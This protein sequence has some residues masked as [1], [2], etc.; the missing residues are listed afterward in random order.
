[1]KKTL[2][3]LCLTLAALVCLSSLSFLFGCGGN[4]PG[5]E[6]SEPASEAESSEPTPEP[7]K[8]PDEIVGGA[9]QK[10][11]AALT[12]APVEGSPLKDLSFL[13]ELD[14]VLLDVDFEKFVLNGA[15]LDFGKISASWT[16]RE[17]DFLGS[18][19]FPLGDNPIEP[20]LCKVGTAYYLYFNGYPELT[21]TV[22]ESELPD[23]LKSI[24]S[25]SQEETP[26]ASVPDLNA[27]KERVEDLKNLFNNPDGV[28]FGPYEETTANDGSKVYTRTLE[29]D[30][31]RA[32]V[33]KLKSL[34]ADLAG[35]AG[36]T[37][38]PSEDPGQETSASEKGEAVRMTQSWALSG[39]SVSSGSV[40][41]F[42]KDDYKLAEITFDVS[43]A[44]GKTSVSAV[45]RDEGETVLEGTY[46]VGKEGDKRT[47]SGS[48]SMPKN[49]FSAEL[50]LTLEDPT[51]TRVAFSATLK[52]TTENDGLTVSFPINV[53]GSFERKPEEEKAAVATLHVVAKASSYCDIDVT[54]KA[55]FC[56]TDTDIS[57][58]ENA[59]PLRSILDSPT[60]FISKMMAAFPA[61]A[62][63][64]GQQED[65]QFETY[66]SEDQ[67]AGVSFSQ[68]AGGIVSLYAYG[69]YT[70]NGTA[71]VITFGEGE[72]L[73]IPY[74]KPDA[75]HIQ[76]FGMELQ[77]VQGDYFTAFT[78]RYDGQ[79]IWYGDEYLYME[80]YPYLGQVLFSVTLPWDGNR[81][82]LD[83]TYPSGDSFSFPLTW[84]ENGMSC[85]F[86]NGTTL[87][88]VSG[89]TTAL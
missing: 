83:F 24:A 10:L 51:E 53:D 84:S 75:D 42:G 16:Q 37:A 26:D 41:V 88:R 74:V 28:S 44:D 49:G 65:L 11:R 36:E 29:G 67:T 71:F 18:L 61:L 66:M 22:D 39:D 14:S 45:F 23:L 72:S 8:T 78:P 21:V 2:R 47:V 81:E 13:K 57:A 31:F 4:K 6:S 80:Q 48:V 50:A 70:D 33:D 5:S 25:A 63:L 40:T 7:V 59:T 86:E 76:M 62:S 12:E 19:K 34:L 43:E 30:D 38:E 87:H 27:V 82:Q 1:M 35:A 68:A 3:L 17:G 32:F 55:T 79:N 9:Y 54:A 15:T 56:L 77:I 85:R 52:V 64:F 60:D 46:A 69:E 89:G 20:N 58:P 73:T